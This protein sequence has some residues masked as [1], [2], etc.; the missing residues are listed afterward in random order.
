M[1][2]RRLTFSMASG[3]PVST[4]NSGQRQDRLLGFICKRKTRTKKGAE[5]PDRARP[6][7]SLWR[8]T[9]HTG[10]VS[11]TAHAHTQKCITNGTDTQHPWGGHLPSDPLGRTG[12]ACRLIWHWPGALWGQSGAGRREDDKPLLAKSVLEKG[13]CMEESAWPEPF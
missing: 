4:E 5:P 1:G 12:L 8:H 3:L 10:N 11:V 13:Q 7:L 2:A 6:F 9:S